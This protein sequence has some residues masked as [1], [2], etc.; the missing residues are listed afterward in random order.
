[1][2]PDTQTEEILEPG[3]VAATTMMKTKMAQANLDRGHDERK[4]TIVLCPKKREQS[5]R[6]GVAARFGLTSRS[7]APGPGRKRGSQRRGSHARR[8]ARLGLRAAWASRGACSPRARARA[9]RRGRRQRRALAT[10]AGRAR[11]HSAQPAVA[12]GGGAVPTRGARVRVLCCAEL[13]GGPAH[14]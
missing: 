1:M 3:D 9:A 7:R 11:M 14:I 10:S 4:T 5:E 12:Q 8:P 6:K 2:R 13:Q